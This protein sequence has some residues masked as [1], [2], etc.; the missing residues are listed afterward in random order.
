MLSEFVTVTARAPMDWRRVLGWAL[1]AFIAWQGYR[2]QS[3][4][5]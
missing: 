5:R 4:R 2:A 3:G 1:V